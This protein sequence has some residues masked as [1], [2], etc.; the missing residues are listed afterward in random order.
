MEGRKR[1]IHIFGDDLLEFIKKQDNGTRKKIMHVF[2]MMEFLSI[3]PDKFFKKLKG[4]ENIY[5]IRVITHFK[6]IRILGFMHKGNLIVLTHAFI[7]KSQKTPKTEI[8]RAIRI[9]AKYYE[10]QNN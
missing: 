8:E 10:Y 4:V 9:K 6:S 3:V 1:E 2:D 7:K 5:E